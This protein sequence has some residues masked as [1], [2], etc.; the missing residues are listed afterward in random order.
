[1][2]YSLSRLFFIV[3]ASTNSTILPGVDMSRILTVLITIALVLTGLSL[4]C[5]KAS[6]KVAEAPEQPISTANDVNFIGGGT[7]HPEYTP[8]ER[9]YVS[10]ST[11]LT[12]PKTS[13]SWVADI[14]AA[15][16]MLESDPHSRVMVWFR[17]NNCEDCLAIERN[18]FT[19]PDVAAASRKWL[20]VRIDTDVNRDRADYYL[21]GADP[22]ALRALDKMGNVYRS[23]NGTFTKE[24]LISMLTTW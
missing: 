7:Q 8:E 22:P 21:H 15:V 14:N 11:G 20:F 6:K 19:D 13:L 12:P 4:S 1:M 5:S 2:I 10:P 17:N 24:D 18:I 3:Q 23:Y 16:R 9:P